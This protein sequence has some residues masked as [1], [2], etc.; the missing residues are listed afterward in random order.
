[1]EYQDNLENIQKKLSDNLKNKHLNVEL[2][3]YLTQP[4]LNNFKSIMKNLEYESLNITSWE[5]N[6]WKKEGFTKFSNFYSDLSHLKKFGLK[7]FVNDLN[8]VG[9]EILAQG[10]SKLIRIEELTLDLT[11]CPVQDQGLNYFL[12][13]ISQL[14]KLES[15]HLLI[16]E[17]KIG[18]DCIDGIF[19]TLQ[20]IIHLK[21]LEISFDINT[22]SLFY[23]E[24]SSGLQKLIGLQKL[25]IQVKAE[26]Q[27]QINEI[28]NSISKLEN[29]RFLLLEIQSNEILIDL[30]IQMIGMLFNCKI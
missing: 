30:D 11:S 14:E 9:S 7:I 21:K 15:I 2:N 17:I 4:Q 20:K 29:I 18:K 3:P 13:A 6:I 22:A 28:T 19:S 10:L 24:I 25:V 16:N 26:K 1:M 23:Q 27:L 12:D 5:Q 8:P